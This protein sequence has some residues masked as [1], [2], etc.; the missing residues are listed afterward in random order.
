MK[1]KLRS[2]IVYLL[3][4]T[5]FNLSLPVVAHAKVIG[6]LASLES[7]QRS[8]DLATVNAALS[9]AEVRA[10]FTRLGVD[11]AVVDMRVASLT[12]SELRQLAQKIDT[13]PA[14]GSFLAVVG[15]VAIVL[16]ILELT[17][18]IDWIKNFP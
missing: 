5:I 4:M 15:I 11:A 6:T 1:Q 16:L 2:G 12:D 7:Q 18:V 9:R 17:G 8:T 14:G 10:Q 13:A 3:V